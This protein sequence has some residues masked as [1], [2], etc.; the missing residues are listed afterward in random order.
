MQVPVNAGG[1]L[2]DGVAQFHVKNQGF[3]LQ[4]TWTINP[5]LTVQYGVRVDT[6]IMPDSPLRNTA[7]AA[8]PV[9]GSVSAP[10]RTRATVTPVSMR[11]GTA[12]RRTGV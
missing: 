3:R 12:S 4:D 2:F 11:A 8:A 1:S 9:A 6:P 5:R 10:C 7:A